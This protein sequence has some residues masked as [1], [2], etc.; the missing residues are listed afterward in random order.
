VFETASRDL[1]R[2][3]ILRE[4]RLE[5][6]HIRSRGAL[7]EAREPGSAGDG[8]T[9]RVEPSVKSAAI[10]SGKGEGRGEGDD[11][12]KGAAEAGD[13]TFTV[14]VQSGPMTVGCRRASTPRKRW[15]AST[16]SLLSSRM[17]GDGLSFG[18]FSGAC[19]SSRR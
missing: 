8:I 14:V 11:G 9:V 5:T 12:G 3:P 19:D 6:G 7:I 2:C 16:V 18:A 15:P 10:E 4:Q 13:D 17:Y 1:D